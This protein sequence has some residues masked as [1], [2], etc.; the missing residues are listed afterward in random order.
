MDKPTDHKFYL[1][2]S[3]ITWCLCQ[4][5]VIY[6]SPRDNYL[7]LLVNRMDMSVLYCETTMT[8]VELA[9]KVG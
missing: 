1:I 8:I 9:H 4:A 2:L 5:P 7:N 6:F 3:G